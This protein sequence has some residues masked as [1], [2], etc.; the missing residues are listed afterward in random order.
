[1]LDVSP[2]YKYDFRG[3]DAAACLSRIMARG[4]TKLAVGRVVYACWTDDAGHIIDDGTIARLDDEHYRVTSASPCVHWFLRH[5]SGFDVEIR[6]TS[7]ELAAL[8]IQGPTSREVLKQISDVDLDSLRFFG[9]T[10]AKLAG[11]DGWI[12]RTGYTGDLGFE[13]WV[14]RAD[15]LTLWDGLMAEGKSYGLMPAG[16]D[17]LDVC[18]V[19]AGFVL[20]GVD[21]TSSL[22]AVIP[23]QKSTPYELGLGWTVKLKNREPFI[24][25]HALEH[26]K[27]A[28]SKWSFVGLDIDWEA[29]E[30]VYD[31]VGLPPAL[32]SAAWREPVPI[33]HQG[34]QI[35]RATSGA[36]SPI[37]KKNLALATVGSGFAEPGTRLD[38][39][40]TVEWARKSVPATVVTTPFFDPARKRTHGDDLR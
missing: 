35:G 31:A 17:A 34:R 39:E 7:S 25:Q 28:G 14:P 15:A 16:L 40:V 27:R 18:R 3:K 20:Q 12:T 30:S 9:A 10:R 11:C 2:L 24:G 13:A 23:S 19:E 5:A 32:P 37:L 8:A 22:E 4:V 21:Y 26:E 38:I 29:L 33:Y 36:W 6:D 1:M